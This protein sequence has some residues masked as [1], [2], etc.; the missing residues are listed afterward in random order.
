VMLFRLFSASLCLAAPFAYS[1]TLDLSVPAGTPLRVYLTK[2]ISKRLG[3]PVEAKL[4]DPLYAFDREVAPAGS[5]VLGSVVEVKPVPGMQRTAAILAGDF[6]PLHQAEIEFTTLVL[7]GGRRIDLHTV[8]TPGLDS[9]ADLNPKKQRAAPK[10]GVIGTAKAQ[11][12]DRID[13]ARKT[14]SDAVR[15]PDKKERLED[16]LWAKLP[17]HP[18]R[19]R[20]LT[21][22]DAEL[23]QPLAF[24]STKLTEADLK[25]VGTQPPADSSVQARL[26]TALNSGDSKQGERVEAV[27]SRPLFSP[28]HQLLL[29]EGTRL[30]GTVTSVHRA[31]W[32]HRGGQLRFNFQTVDLPEGVKRP[33]VEERKSEFKTLAM[34][35]AAE[36]DGKTNRKVDSE[37][38]VK[39][40]E[41]KT[42]FVAPLLAAWIAS[43]AADQDVNKRTGVPDNNTGGR[44]LGGASG[45]GLLGAAAAKA[46]PNVARVFGY[47]GLAWSVYTNVIA[48][49]KE[50]E[51]QKNAAID[52]RFGA[53]APAGASHLAR[54]TPAAKAVTK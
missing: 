43:R 20:R 14:V 6:T 44:T 19:I 17:Y 49:G 33:E 23:A 25:L 42:R 4:L 50:V 34:L 24:G 27:L 32:F 51:F 12:Q 5:Q 40:T 29:P 41:S 54:N 2:R 37:G 9:L 13:T 21:R 30:T 46:S 22:F 48:R 15:A 52:I 53:R 10:K 47:Y 35:Q 18:Q 3:E 31:R 39:A 1:Q 45:F 38:G 16:F 7:P 26:V 36:P 8:A 28:T 11:A